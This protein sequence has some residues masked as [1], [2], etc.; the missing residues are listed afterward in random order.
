MTEQMLTIAPWPAASITGRAARVVRTAAIR[1]SVTKSEGKLTLTF[2]L[3]M[4]PK[5]YGRTIG[6]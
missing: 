6:M 3:K 1:F 2:F 5:S 4:S